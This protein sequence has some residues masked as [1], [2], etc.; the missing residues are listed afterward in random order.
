MSTAL[1]DNVIL[2]S[3]TRNGVQQIWRIDSDGRDA[4]VVVRGPNVQHQAISHDRRTIAYPQTV[5]TG[6]NAFARLRI[7]AADGTHDRPLYPTPS[8]Q[9][10]NAGR[11]T[12]S[13]D[14]TMLAVACQI[15]STNGTTRFAI[16][17]VDMSGTFVGAPLATGTLGDLTFNHEGTEVGYWEANPN[18]PA[19]TR[20]AE[21]NV[22]GPPQP[23]PLTG[24]LRSVNDATFSPVDD[25]IAMRIG[26]TDNNFE[27]YVLRPGAKTPVRLTH[28][29][30]PDQDPS[31]SPNGTQ[32]AYK[33]GPSLNA[34][35]W[36][37]N[38]NGSNQH[39]LVTSKQ[40]DTTP[41]WTAR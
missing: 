1:H 32:L 5:G 33:H 18:N 8:A 7:A 12:F 19:L 4:H 29:S 35:I 38:A 3:A 17:L 11:P 23:K 24:W 16:R 20:L 21:V 37:M 6:A 10:P 25:S 31:W 15:P 28:N 14:D 22:T 9:C 40:P 34:D 13:P 39:P 26:D 36:V 41:S 27:I 2:W 30:V